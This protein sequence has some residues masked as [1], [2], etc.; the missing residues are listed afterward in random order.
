MEV[1]VKSKV[2]EVDINSKI[3]QLKG[4]TRMNTHTISMERTLGRYG[5]YSQVVELLI[6][7]E[8]LGQVKIEIKSEGVVQNENLQKLIEGIFRLKNSD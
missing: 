7:D 4:L 8:D 6:F 2:T 3:L 1:K 5:L